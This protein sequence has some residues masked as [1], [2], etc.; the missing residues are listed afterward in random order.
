MS[1]KDDLEESRLER[2]NSVDRAILA[3]EEEEGSEEV[4]NWLEAVD[5]GL[6]TH[7]AL[8][9]ALRK[10][11]MTNVEDRRVSEWIKKRERA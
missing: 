1:I 10:Y 11:S 4:A 6:Y 3:L 5:S 8:A 2:M 7:A 9:G